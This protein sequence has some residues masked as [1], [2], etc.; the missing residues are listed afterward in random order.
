LI[1][2]SGRELPANENEVIPDWRIKST[3]NKQKYIIHVLSTQQAFKA[4]MLRCRKKVLVTTAGFATFLL[5]LNSEMLLANKAIRCQKIFRKGC[6]V[7]ANTCGQVGLEFIQDSQVFS[8]QVCNPCGSKSQNIRQLYHCEKLELL[9]RQ[10][11]P[12]K[13]VV[14]AI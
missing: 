1:A 9:K 3:F 12:V 5:Q 14:K 4:T 7:L 2:F 8:D 13:A 10:A 6:I 11:L